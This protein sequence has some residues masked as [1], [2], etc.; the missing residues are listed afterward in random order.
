VNVTNQR[1]AVDYAQVL[2]GKR[3]PRRTFRPDAG[4]VSVIS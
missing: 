3:C 1:A 4:S 2:K